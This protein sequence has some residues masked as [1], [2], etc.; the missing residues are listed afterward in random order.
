MK[1]LSIQ[2]NNAILENT[3]TEAASEKLVS[4]YIRENNL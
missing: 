2:H 1:V 4:V 3:S